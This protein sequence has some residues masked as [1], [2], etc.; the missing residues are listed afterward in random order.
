MKQY[1]QI[2]IR[3]RLEQL[4]V[5]RSA[6]RKGDGLE[7]LV[8][9]LF[10]A[11][12]GMA[13]VGRNVFNRNRSREI[14]IALKI[15]TRKSDFYFLEHLVAV[16]CKYTKKPTDSMEVNW[17]ANKIKSLGMT[18]GLLFAMGSISGSGEQYA[19]HEIIEARKM[20]GVRILV[21]NK[22]ELL[23]LTNSEQFASMLDDKLMALCF[24]DQ[25]LIA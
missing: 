6:D 24:K 20:F 5:E 3:T 21:V 4:T 23:S 13:V 10:E 19:Y 12:E 17:F 1:S 2:E 14:D 8:A 7:C 11:V 16:E 18:T 9:E 22:N 15:D 25:V